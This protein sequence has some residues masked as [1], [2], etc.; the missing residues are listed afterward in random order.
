MLE[1]ID[2]AHLYLYNGVIIPSVSEILN[3]YL[4]KDKYKYVPE[5]ILKAKAE[6]G[7]K[8]HEAIE[9][10]EKNNKMLEGL[11]IH[12]EL[13]VEQYLKIKE[14]YNLQVLKQEEMV[15]YKGIYAGRFDML[16][17]V[18]GKECL[19]DIKTTAELDLEYL[20]WQLSLYELAYGKKLEKLYA[21][22]LPKKGLG[23]LIEIERKSLEEIEKVIE[24]EKVW[25]LEKDK[26]LY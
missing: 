1:Y 9:Y 12:Q 5:S 6:Y 18:N 22:W 10:L 4:F 7:S 19:I 13:S 14:K 15:C 3:K 21:L 25:N 8:V 16:A 17:N 2:E 11:N 23:K 26:K 24:G 20:S